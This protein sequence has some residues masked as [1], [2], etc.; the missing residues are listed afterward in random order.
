MLAAPIHTSLSNLL[1][2]ALLDLD[3]S[4]IIRSFLFKK[5]IKRLRTSLAGDVDDDNI[6][7]PDGALAETTYLLQR[8]AAPIGSIG[9]LRA[10]NSYLSPSFCAQDLLN[11]PD[12]RKIVRLRPFAARVYP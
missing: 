9:A 5:H 2:F 10:N 11:I 6:L 3:E 12:N 4:Y 8:L 1:A 7:Q